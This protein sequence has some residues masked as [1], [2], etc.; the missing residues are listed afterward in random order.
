M[1]QDAK[2][3]FFEILSALRPEFVLVLGR[4]LWR[5]MPE[6][7]AVPGEDRDFY[8]QYLIGPHIAVAAATKHPSSFGFRYADWQPVVARGLKLAAR[9]AGRPRAGGRGNARSGLTSDTLRRRAVY[10]SRLPL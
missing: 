3:P 4:A 7:P 5:Q 2:E 9:N 6:A 10:N 8:R 1:W